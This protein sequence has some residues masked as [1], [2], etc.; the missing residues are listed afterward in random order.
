[1]RASAI[2]AIVAVHPIKRTC[3]TRVH[4][5]RQRITAFETF[6]S[7]TGAL[8]RNSVRTCSARTCCSIAA[9]RSPP[10]PEVNPARLSELDRARL[11]LPREEACAT[12]Y[13]AASALTPL[14]HSMRTSWLHRHVVALEEPV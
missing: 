10:P 2:S 11:E 14:E 8:C 4:K 1:M 3:G 7:S 12:H 13:S 6:A 5:T 9:S